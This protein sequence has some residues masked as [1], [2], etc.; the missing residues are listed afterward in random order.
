MK[1]VFGFILVLVVFVACSTEK[2]GFLNRKYH[3][4]TARYNGLFNANELLKGALRTY[5]TSRKEDFYTILPVNPLPNESDVKGMLPALDTAISKCT[6]VIRNHSMPSAEN[7]YYKEVE[8]NRWIDENWI[9]IGKS[10]YYKRDYDKA[11]QNF[12]FVKKF[13]KKDPST[14]DAELWSAKIL[15]EQEKYAEAK[16]SLDGLSEVSQAQKKRKF[17]DFIQLAFVKKTEGKEKQVRMKRNLQFEIYKANADLAIRRR[18]PQLAI[19]MLNLAI[20]KSPSVREKTRLCYILGQLYQQEKQLDSAAYFYSKSVRPSAPFDI[21]FNGRLNE[22]ICGKGNGMDR[23]LK[24]MLRDAKNAAFKDQIYFALAKVELNQNDKKQAKIYLTQS[25]FYSN[26]N[27]RQ[28]A[29]S[30]ETLGDLSYSDRDYISAQKYYDSC[31]RFVT[32]DYPNGDEIK[33]KAVKLADLVKSVETALF[34]DSV[35]RIAKMSEKDRTD[36]LKETLKQMKEDIQRK[37]ELEAQ[38]LLALQSQQNND[39][40]N[41]ANKFVFNN[42]KLRETGFKEF[43]KQW[44]PRENEDDWRRSNKIIFNNNTEED[45]TVVN[46]ESE[47]ELKDSLTIEQLLAKIP[48]TDSAFQSSRLKMQEAYYQAGV[49]YKEILNEASLASEQFEL[50]LA[51]K[52]INLTDLSTAFQLYKLNE[53]GGAAYKYRN[54]IVIN[55]PNSDAAKYFEDPDFYVKLKASQQQAQSKYLSLVTTYEKGN[56]Q[57]VLSAS[58][59]IISTEP[60]NALRAEY[61][62]LNALAFGQLNENKQELVPRLKKV[63]DEK[64]GTPQ[65]I[66]AKEMLEIIKNGYSKNEPVNFNKTYSFAYNSDVAQYVIVLMDDE[67]DVDDAKGVIS[68]FT[69]RKLRLTKLKVSPKLT[70]AEKH[71][72]LI[73]EFAKIKDAEEYVNA[74]KAGFEDLGDYQD[75][76]IYI[77]TQENLKKLIESSKFE[78]YKLFYDDNY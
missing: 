4:T 66:R 42:P 10:M 76:K 69:T 52:E 24:T 55:Y 63:I 33:N 53:Q 3:G 77:I 58:D 61:L 14:Y 18:D 21:S 54:H 23:K 50:A 60:A 30:Y 65:A 31:S 74:F 27:K 2:A 51:V 45:T 20:K 8:Y 67:D 7:M 22:A 12:Q 6:K 28:R 57:E 78:E 47:K 59:L 49:L 75:N 16:L 56:Y 11:F 38:K 46:N 19:N 9:T 71:M 36:F 64:P 34:E 26:N 17:K 68:D 5:Y 73:Q 15:I 29:M 39:V 62:L 41:N 37:K 44:G 70:L 32:D 48:L 13:F 25:A 1:K 40:G 72:V 35:Q 43:Q